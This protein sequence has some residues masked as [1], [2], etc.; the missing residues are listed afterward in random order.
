LLLAGRATDR[1]IVLKRFHSFEPGH[2][3]SDRPFFRFTADWAAQR[4]IAVLHLDI[5]ARK[6]ILRDGAGRPHAAGGERHF[7][8][9]GEF[10]VGVLTRHGLVLIIADLALEWSAYA[11][12][13]AIGCVGRHL[14]IFG[15][16][17]GGPKLLLGIAAADENGQCARG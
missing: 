13:R 9:L 2:L 6:L 16:I 12:I 7:N 14:A 1:E 10:L 4:H 5:N 11:N 17:R 3:L 8:L 15:D